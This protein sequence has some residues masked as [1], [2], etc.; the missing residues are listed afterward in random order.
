MEVVVYELVEEVVM[1]VYELVEEV[2][3]VVYE[4]VEDVVEDL[5]EDLVGLVDE[6][7]VT[8]EVEEWPAVGGAGDV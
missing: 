8:K 5:V 4:P 2:V 6:D 1:V 7:E 3:V